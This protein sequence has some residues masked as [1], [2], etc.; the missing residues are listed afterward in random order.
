MWVGKTAAMRTFRIRA[1]GVSCLIIAFINFLKLMQNQKTIDK[2]FFVSLGCRALLVAV[3]NR[4]SLPYYKKN[5]S[6]IQ[7][8]FI[9]IR[10]V[11]RHGFYDFSV[12]LFC[13][14]AVSK[15]SD[16]IC[17]KFRQIV[18]CECRAPRSRC[19]QK[20]KITKYTRTVVGSIDEIITKLWFITKNKIDL[21]DLYR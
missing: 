7:H 14:Y 4:L 11:I 20:H 18:S 2:F 6:Q 15:G 3:K 5:F 8:N 16:S 17:L 10:I 1:T 19:R 21:H 13:M 9:V 12:P